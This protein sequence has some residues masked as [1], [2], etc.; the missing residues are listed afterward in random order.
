MYHVSIG[1]PR[2]SRVDELRVFNYRLRSI[3]R[4]LN[5]CRALE[6]YHSSKRIMSSTPRD[7]LE[8]AYMKNVYIQFALHTEISCF[9]ASLLLPEL[10]GV[11]F[12]CL[13]YQ[14]FPFPT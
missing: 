4:H 1:C 9:F 7:L 6:T 13:K 10:P 5:F 11:H 8:F 14:L 12:F 3:L 2:D